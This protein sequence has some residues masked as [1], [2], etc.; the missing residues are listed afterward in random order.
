MDAP[1]KKLSVPPSQPSTTAYAYCLLFYKEPET[2]TDLTFK[3]RTLPPFFVTAAPI[4]VFYIILRA[5]WSGA[6]CQNYTSK[7]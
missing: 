5:G 1:E 7:V 4:P 6:Q 3:T 2:R